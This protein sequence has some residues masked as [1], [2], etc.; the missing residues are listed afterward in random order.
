MPLTL[1]IGMLTLAPAVLALA[2]LGVGLAKYARLPVVLGLAALG[3]LVPAISLPFLVQ[4]LA[5]GELLLPSPLFG[6]VTG[7]NAWLSAAYR[8]DA[9]GVFAAYGI[10]F[11]I[12]PIL[13]WMAVHG[14]F[15]EV[16]PD[17]LP[18]EPA[19]SEDEHAADAGAAAPAATTASANFMQRAMR[20]LLSPSQWGGVAVA[21]GLESAALTLVFAD[22]VVWL[23]L[24]WIVLAAL[25]WALGEMGSDVQTLDRA[26]LGLMLAGPALWLLAI[27]LPVI[28]KQTPR[29][30]FAMLSD[31][32]GRGGTAP[33]F[34]ILLAIALALAGGA[35]PF[36]IW[37]RR[38]AGL[39]TPAGLAAIV[40]A[41]LPIVL[42]VGART[43]SALQDASNKWPLFGSA[44]PQTTT[45]QPPITAGIA[46]AVLGALTVGMGG[47][48]AL[49]RQDGRSLVALLAVTQV[50]WG[51]LAIGTGTPASA[52]GLTL[53]LATSV[54]G[55]GAMLSALYAGGTLLSDIEPEATGPRALGGPLR[56]LHLA[57]WSLGALTLIGAPLFAGFLSR[58][59][60]SVGAM[61]TRGLAVP[62][63]ALAWIGDGLLALA[64]LRATAPAFARIVVSAPS[65]DEAQVRTGRMAR[66]G[67]DVAGLPGMVL[68]V[69]AL[70]AGI[71]PQALLAIGGTLAASALVQGGAAAL[72]LDVLPMGYNLGGTQWLPTL[73][74]IAVVMIGLLITF[75][76]QGGAR[77]Q[78]ASMLSGQT[79]L[80]AEATARAQ[81]AA[82]SEPQ[83]AWSDL[84]RTFTASVVL[85]GAGRLA[86][87]AEP[88]E[89][90]LSEPEM[91]EE[92]EEAAAEEEEEATAGLEHAAVEDEKEAV[93]EG[94]STVGSS[95]EA[96]TGGTTVT[97]EQGPAKAAEEPD[98]A[99]AAGAE[100][101]APEM[102]AASGAAGEDTTTPPFSM[103]PRSKQGS[104]GRPRSMRKGD[105]S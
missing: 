81:A 67:L 96:A 80:P 24:S 35:Y 15:A 68:A 12:T 90:E 55:L 101:T 104:S 6:G 89:A 17:T 65:H 79:A 54:F 88:A 4:G 100:A 25:G 69:L 46:F 9:F 95:G 22:N 32:M 30:V 59:M 64:L 57:A 78:R 20:R 92:E 28:S 10:V 41:L 47:L 50:G 77:E 82:L 21:L 18:V 74:W 76:L 52:L 83:D 45:G 26:G 40:L 102:S 31:M 60:I 27:L 87:E 42:F 36:T 48:L 75:L 16:A 38:R 11:I 19:Q 66:L 105:K 85:P 99:K 44:Q 3:A 53:L 93:V 97:A 103:R 91:V 23:G 58:Q 94:D 14:E 5:S 84:A 33:V 37:V 1:F 73:A 8:I 70:V 61:Q 39:I 13:L 7:D 86:R 51:L 43:Y 72:Q 49:A 98:V 62:L 71:V 29:S 56:P 2:V 63:L 34:V